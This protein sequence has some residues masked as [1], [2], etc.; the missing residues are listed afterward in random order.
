MSVVRHSSFSTD[1]LP[2]RDRFDA[3][4]T[5]FS[6]HDLDA[7]PHGFSARIDT[8]QIGP[9]LL[10]VMNA[11]PQRTGRTR[12]KI[13][14]DGQ[15][16][17]TLLLSQH[18]YAIESDH[19]TQKVPPGAFTLND[20]SQ[21][22]RRSRVRETNSLIVSLARDSVARL[23]PNEETL[24]GAILA[25]PT[26]CLLAE[27][28]RG[29]VAHRHTI[30]TDQALDIAQATLHLLAA[31]A[32]PD[33]DRQAMASAPASMARLSASKRYIRSNLAKALTVEQIASAV[34]LSRTRLY[35]LFEPEGGVARYLMQ[36]RLAAVRA[37][38]DD[39][40]EGRNIG[41]INEAYGFGNFSHFSRTFREAYG[42]SPRD[43]RASRKTSGELELPSS[44]AAAT[45]MRALG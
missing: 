45:W 39:P 31:I 10:H 38:L 26:A 35:H 9:V 8:T 23:L 7:D 28:L 44:P 33:R 42:Q 6:A 2:E 4:R 15:E 16:R 25:G 37:A 40:H 3:W 14:Q 32:R 17:F 11:S 30:G 22:Y 12:S 20:L 34:G 5:L 41:V 13:R 24:H 18:T 1:D 29:L 43:Y 21:P 36:Q 27:H 19:G